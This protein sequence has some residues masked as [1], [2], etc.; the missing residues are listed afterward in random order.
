MSHPNLPPIDTSSET[1]DANSVPT[2]SATLNVESLVPTQLKM[3][4][5]AEKEKVRRRLCNKRH[6]E[7]QKS[8]HNLSVAE[9]NKKMTKITDDTTTQFEKLNCDVF[10]DI[11]D[12][13]YRIQSF[14]PTERIVESKRCFRW[15]R[16]VVDDDKYILQFKLFDG[17]YVD[18]TYIAKSTIEN[19]G[20]G[21]FAA[22]NLPK[23]LPF[24]IYLGR[25]VQ[26]NSKKRSYV[27]QQ[28]YKYV[29]GKNGNNRWEKIRK[30]RKP[31]FIDG[32]TQD[33]F[34]K[35]TNKREFYLGAHMLNDLNYNRTGDTICCNCVIQPMLEV[36]TKQAIDK[37]SELFINYNY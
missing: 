4:D 11:N 12:E 28:N 29:K 8:L 1:N 25:V 26:D 35:W 23:G 17:V 15:I 16:H 24:T 13:I 37:D 33:S 3:L 32:L 31:T 27:I 30:D 36:V 21:M 14:C 10:S 18:L 6:Y 5:F 2:S 19:A 22:M 34:H 9:R 20:Y 7:K